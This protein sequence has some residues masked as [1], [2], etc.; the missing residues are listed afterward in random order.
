M[1]GGGTSKVP[2]VHMGPRT[3]YTFERN[4][5]KSAFAVSC[6]IPR[7]PGNTQGPAPRVLGAGAGLFSPRWSVIFRRQIS[8]SFTWPAPPAGPQFVAGEG[9][10]DLAPGDP[11]LGHF[12]APPWTVRRGTASLFTFIRCTL[13]TL[14][15]GGGG[16]VDVDF[17]PPCFCQVANAL[18]GWPDG[19]AKGMW[20]DGLSQENLKAEPTFRFSS[21]LNLGSPIFRF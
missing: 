18:R 4:I 16:G 6:Q 9:S 2:G 7:R 14:F 11:I 10:W 3:Q 5:R 12:S 1:K 17:L 20:A 8:V 15:R 21:Q 13:F 19:P